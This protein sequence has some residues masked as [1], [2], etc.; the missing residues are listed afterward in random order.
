[1][2]SDDKSKA[3]GQAAKSPE[4][5]APAEDKGTAVAPGLDH[6]EPDSRVQADQEAQR[7]AQSDPWGNTPLQS[8]DTHDAAVDPQTDDLAPAPGPKP[9]G[10][11]PEATNS[12]TPEESQVQGTLPPV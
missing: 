1:M 11:S 6:G 8:R 4:R 12:I 2:A 3:E 7:K 10:I 9:S 5:E